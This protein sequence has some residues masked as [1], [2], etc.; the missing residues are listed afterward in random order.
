VEAR[1]AE[2]EQLVSDGSLPVASAARML[3]SAESERERLAALPQRDARAEYQP[4]AQTVSAHWATL[5][6]GERGQFYR[7][8]QITC[9]ADAAGVVVRMPWE[10]AG[11]DDSAERIARAFG[12]VP[13]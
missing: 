2:I 8:W 4:T 10:S 12:L 5:D 7:D 9:Y 6:R 3:A 13:A 11:T 1:I